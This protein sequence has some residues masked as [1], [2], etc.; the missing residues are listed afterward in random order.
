MSHHPKIDWPMAPLLLKRVGATYSAMSRALKTPEVPAIARAFH[1]VGE[2]TE[3]R[4]RNLWDGTLRRNRP[5]EE[6]R[7]LCGDEGKRLGFHLDNNCSINGY[8]TGVL[9]PLGAAI[10]MRKTKAVGLLLDVGAPRTPQA[11]EPNFLTLLLRGVPAKAKPTTELLAVLHQ[12][13][14]E[15]DVPGHGSPLEEFLRRAEDVLDRFPVA[16]WLDALA[17][18]NLNWDHV[19]RKPGE[20]ILHVLARSR[21]RAKAMEV[22]LERLHLTLEMFE[23]NNLDGHSPLSIAQAK[24]QSGIQHPLVSAYQR[25]LSEHRSDVA[26]NH[27]ITPRALGRRQR[28]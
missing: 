22:V 19:E 1:E 20:N 5:L 25:R 7:W 11:Q 16:G 2:L 14:V 12:G 21:I 6:L 27:N 28:A 10:R 13:Q 23:A 15:L 4:R 17:P 3:D 18:L 8:D 9:S 26:L 24:S